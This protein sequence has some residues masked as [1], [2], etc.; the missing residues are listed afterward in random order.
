MARVE[1]SSSSTD[2]IEKHIVLRAPRSRVWRALTDHREFGAWFQA[3]LETPFVEGQSVRGRIT[4][5]G[6][7][8]LTFD[9]TVVRLE[10]ERFF[11]MR[12]QPGGD[13][14]PGEPTTLV[15][16]SLEEV[17]G[18]TR[19]TVVETGFDQF[20]PERRAKVFRDNDGGWA[21]QLGNIARYVGR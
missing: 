20:S 1:S 3:V 19:L 15:E 14:K 6:Y 12:W 10:P 16:F 13:P 7:E 18:G 4:V 17:P 11:S 21:E 8:H 5:P 2:R 9:A